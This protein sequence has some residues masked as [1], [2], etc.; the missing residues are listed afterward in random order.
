MIDNDIKFTMR[1]V[2]IPFGYRLSYKISLLCL[3]LK[4][5]CDPRKSCSLIKLQLIITTLLSQHNLSDL[6][7]ICKDKSYVLTP[8]RFDPSINKAITFA[9]KDGIITKL[10]NGNYKLTQLGKIFV[11]RILDSNILSKE[12]EELKT[13]GIVDDEMLNFIVNTW[14]YN[15]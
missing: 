14:R 5:S 6:V 2:A 3:C 8:I 9:L 12:T 1:P 4:I 13:L 11:D 10:A 7:K 15:D